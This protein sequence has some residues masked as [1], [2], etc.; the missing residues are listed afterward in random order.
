MGSTN[1]EDRAYHA[2]NQRY[3]LDE[4][5]GT[6]VVCFGKYRG[7]HQFR[8]VVSPEGD[9]AYCEWVRNTE[10]SQNR[11]PNPQFQRFR[12]YLVRRHELNSIIE[13]VSEEKRRGVER[14]REEEREKHRVAAAEALQREA[15]LREEILKERM[16]TSLGS[17][18]LSLADDSLFFHSEILQYLD[19]NDIMNLPLVCS[20][21]SHSTWKHGDWLRV[22]ALA[23]ARR[24]GGSDN[25]MRQD[26][27][28]R[29][30]FGIPTKWKV[31]CIRLFEGNLQG[32]AEHMHAKKI[33]E[34]FGQS[35]GSIRKELGIAL[36]SRKKRT[37]AMAG[38]NSTFDILTIQKAN[39]LTVVAT[40][41]V[42]KAIHEA[43]LFFRTHDVTGGLPRVFDS[44]D[45]DVWTDFGTSDEWN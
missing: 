12:K 39:N 22:I 14:M 7:T 30:H 13:Q 34:T 38:I 2:L 16:S 1:D 32:F 21:L 6:T 35:Y 33:M 24:R 28:L 5:Q 41:R 43:I 44:S 42:V 20:D 8:Q 4:L 45:I 3:E 10:E 27:A 17:Q 18:L 31:P 37:G 40:E 23:M 19:L 9:R 36:R 15:E 29:A 26:S 11:D 25:V